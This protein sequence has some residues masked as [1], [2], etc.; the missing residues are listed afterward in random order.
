MILKLYT[1]PVIEP[2][3][4]DELRLHL[5]LDAETVDDHE[6]DSLLTDLITT[7][8]VHVE[9]I[10]RRALLSQT[11]E[12]CL[13]DFPDGK[14]IKLP[15]G[16]LQS[17]TSVKYKNT[18]GT[19]TTMAVT[20][21]YLTE[22][23]GEQCGRVVLPYNVSWPSTTLYPSNPITIRY[24]AGWTTAALVPGNIRAAV[25]MICADM[26]SNRE[27]Q[28]F[29][30]SGQEYAENKTVERLLASARLWDEF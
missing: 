6:E 2:I 3:S 23:N 5:R 9:N 22:T 17:V 11:W 4:I 28:V 10:T 14:S 27:A 29:G 24:I 13:N 21:E 30:Q 7:A 12:Y 16:N 15:L 20:T 25:K 26:Y 18:A 8:R 1:A 19:E